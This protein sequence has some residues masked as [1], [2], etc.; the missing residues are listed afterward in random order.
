MEYFDEFE[1]EDL[2]NILVLVESCYRIKLEGEEEI[3]YFLSHK[4]LALNQGR[5]IVKQC[6]GLSLK[7]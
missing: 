4:D 2:I 6:T 3:E 1:V 5:V 7:S